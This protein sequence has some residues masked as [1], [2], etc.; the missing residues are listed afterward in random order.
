MRRLG[1]YLVDVAAIGLAAAITIIVIGRALDSSL[2]HAL[3]GVPVA[4]DLINGIRAEWQQVYD[5]TAK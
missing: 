5:P 3:D 4:G 1:D 2:G